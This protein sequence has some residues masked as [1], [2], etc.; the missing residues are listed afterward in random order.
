[1]RILNATLCLFLFGAPAFAQLGSIPVNCTRGESL[2]RAVQFA[3]PGTT[4][5]VKGTCQGPI[6]IQTSGLT[7]NGGG[8]ATING[9][10]KDAV[11][12]IGAHHVTLSG[13]SVMGGKNGVVAEGNAQVSLQAVTVSGGAATGLLVEDNSSAILNNAV[14]S[15]NALDGVDVESSSS[16]TVNGSN[17][18][19]GNTVFGLDI[20][21]GSSLT[22]TGAS[23]SVTG[24]SV[25]VQVGTN[26][27]AFEDGASTLSAT[28]NG[29]IGLTMV[30]GGHMVDFGGAITADGNGLQGIALDS[31]AGLDLDAG[32]QVEADN[33]SGDGVHL[34]MHSVMTIF[35]TPAFSGNPNTT[36]LTVQGNQADG[37]NLLTDSEILVD[38]VAEVQVEG[39]S[40]AGIGL[41]DGS[42]FSF[43]QTVLVTGVNSNIVGNSPDVNLTFSSRLTTLG[44]DNFGVVKC[45]ATSLV[46]GSL[47]VTCPH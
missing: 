3:F 1:M 5:L 45:D 38:N 9:G 34:E 18:I 23:L 28:G 7:L 42:S 22:L 13:I 35:N 14:I 12:I 21:N 10:G 30:S 20:N 16:L 43:G 17:I 8:S 44:N 41:D 27:S 24:N 31:K 4:L 29:A 47:A 40:Q 36:L 15:S 26:A 19:A 32:S 11:T 25:G 46:R 37:I 39:N 2:A 33:N 6:V